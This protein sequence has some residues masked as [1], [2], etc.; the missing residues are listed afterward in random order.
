M[1]GQTV[2][3]TQR[4]R[5]RNSKLV[6]FVLRYF[7][8]VNAPRVIDMCPREAAPRSL[9]GGIAVWRV[10]Q[11]AGVLRA[12][13]QELQAGLPPFKVGRSVYE[14]RHANESAS[15]VLNSAFEHIA[16]GKLRLCRACG[17]CAVAFGSWLR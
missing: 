2:G 9:S 4:A 13:R 8:C 7:R 16:V 14:L 15:P 3:G 1:E 10:R 5:G 12:G 11:G 6:A 17:R